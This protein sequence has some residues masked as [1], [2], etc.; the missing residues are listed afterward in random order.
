[1]MGDILTKSNLGNEINSVLS[2]I[3]GDT[4]V[5]KKYMRYGFGFW[6]PMSTERQ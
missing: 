6:R 1:M 5:G 2:A 4:R 3:G